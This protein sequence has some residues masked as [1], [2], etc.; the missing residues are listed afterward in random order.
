MLNS[1]I[2]LIF[3]TKKMLVSLLITFQEKGIMKM[4]FHKY[5]LTSFLFTL[6]VCVNAQNAVVSAGGDAVST[7]AS[8]AFTVG[9]AGCTYYAMQGTQFSAGIQLGKVE[10]GELTGNAMVKGYD[11]VN[12]AVYPNPTTNYVVVNVNDKRS[13]FRYSLT[14]HTGK[15]MDN[16]VLT[17]GS[18]LSLAGWA[19]G[20]Y[21]LTVEATEEKQMAKTVRIVKE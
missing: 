8:F 19:S 4:L 16:G 15:L 6:T 7:E 10:E 3:V 11:L 21:L 20:V 12:V 5:S 13:Q 18:Q 1:I 17:N 14:D 2:I 9:E